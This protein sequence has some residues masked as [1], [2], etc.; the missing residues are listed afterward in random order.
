MS[1]SISEAPQKHRFTGYTANDTAYPYAVSFAVYRVRCHSW[2]GREEGNIIL[3]NIAETWEM[4]QSGARS[5]PGK[6]W[7]I[8]DPKNSKTWGDEAIR[9]AKRAREILGVFGVQKQ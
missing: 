8:W 5:V 7:G 6:N 4:K 2:R 9:R 3:F 1:E